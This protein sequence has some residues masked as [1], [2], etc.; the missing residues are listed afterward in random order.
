MENP[1]KSRLN[2]WGLMLDQQKPILT[3][4]NVNKFFDATQVLFN[5]NLTLY[6]GE[7][8]CILGPSGS[9]K[10]TLLR[11][12][13]QLE[14]IEGG[15]IRLD[16]E[17]IGNKKNGQVYRPL[18]NRKKPK[19]RRKLGMVFQSFNLFPH[20]TVLENITE[21]PR[22]IKHLSRQ[23]A[24]NRAIELLKKVGLSGWASSYPAQLSGGQ[25]QRVAIVRALAMDPEIMLFDEPTSALDPELVGEVLR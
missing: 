19:Q 25:Q 3:V 21:G 1:R 24:E 23:D 13:N 14:T 9:G 8:T 17:L 22:Y 5:V 16:N 15:E 7:V 6:S 11:C 18:S 20:R 12:L 2:V 4:N 10:S